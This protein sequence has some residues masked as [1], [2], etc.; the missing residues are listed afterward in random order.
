MVLEGGDRQSALLT[1][2]SFLGGARRTESVVPRSQ[3][4]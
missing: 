1:S 2:V 4:K 3:L